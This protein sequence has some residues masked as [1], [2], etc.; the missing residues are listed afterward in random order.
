MLVSKSSSNIECIKGDGVMKRKY[1]CAVYDKMTQAKLAAWCIENGFDITVG[2]GGVKQK[3]SDFEFH[4]TIV[5]SQSYHAIPNDMIKVKKTLVKPIEMV[6]LGEK[7]DIPVIKISDT[8]LA[9]H[10]DLLVK[11]FDVKE[12]WPDFKPHISVSYVPT[13]RDLK[14]IALPR[15]PIYFDK[16]KIEDIAE[17]DV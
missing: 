13:D 15:F 7:G 1:I 6:Y 12:K 5:Y 8:A 2:Y 4:S 17:K 11:E 3:A 14:A 10:H 9:A 16:I